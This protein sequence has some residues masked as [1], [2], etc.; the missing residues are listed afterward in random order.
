M[1]TRTPPLATTR[2]RPAHRSTFLPTKGARESQ[3]HRR[4]GVRTSSVI[5]KTTRLIIA[6]GVPVEFLFCF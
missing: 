5:G 4:R 6:N 3:N 2:E 1:A